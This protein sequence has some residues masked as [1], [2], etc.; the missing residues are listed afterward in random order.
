MPPT[1]P[2]SRPQVRRPQVH[3]TATVTDRCLVALGL[4][5][6]AYGETDRGSFAELSP[7]DT[8]AYAAMLARAADTAER[9]EKTDATRSTAA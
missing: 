9:L 3:L 7:A 6:A 2:T 1:T 4:E 5:R 8:R